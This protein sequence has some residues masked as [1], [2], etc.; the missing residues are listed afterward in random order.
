M[1]ILDI[2]QPN[3]IDINNEI[4]LRKYDYPN[5]FALNWYNDEETLMLI[6]GKNEPYDMSRLN[7]MY[8]YLDKYGELYYIEFKISDPYMPIVIGNKEYRGKGIGKK[9][10][11]KLIERGKKLG[12]SEF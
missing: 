11:I 3:I 2:N 9:V 10:I 5:N 12:Y 4:R 8:S 1:P 7:Q 6:D